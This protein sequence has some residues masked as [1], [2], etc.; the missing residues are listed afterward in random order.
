MA[1]GTY[2]YNN[3][4]LLISE[5]NYSDNYKY[6]IIFLYYNVSMCTLYILYHIYVRNINDKKLA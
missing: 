3:I 6:A 1:V 4:L 5:W 2:H